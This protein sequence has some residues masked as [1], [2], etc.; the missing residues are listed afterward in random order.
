MET[1]I[2]D[3]RKI[4]YMP[5]I[6]KLSL[7]LPYVHILVTGR[8]GKTRRESFKRGSAYQDV[9][10]HQYYSERVVA[11]FVHQIQS[12]YYGGNRYMYIKGIALGKFSSTY[13]G[14]SSSSY[15]ILTHHAMFP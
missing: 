8:C 9:L 7:H 14:T 1:S 12:E 11:S 6:H 3:F 13:Q 4:F 15:H 10:C 5:A 2:V